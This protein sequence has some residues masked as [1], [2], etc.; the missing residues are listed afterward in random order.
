MEVER[1]VSDASSETAD[2]TRQSLTKFMEWLG[3]DIEISKIDTP[4][5][6]RFQR[7]RLA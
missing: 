7:E 5:L 2:R 4:L 6:E 3:G 1:L